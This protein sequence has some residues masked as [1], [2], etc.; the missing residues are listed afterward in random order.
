VRCRRENRAPLMLGFLI[1]GAIAVALALPQLMT[2]TFPQ[3]LGGG[4]LKIRFNWV[5]NQGDGTLIDGYFWFW[6]K[7]V[8]LVYLLIVPAILS[9]KKGGLCRTLG[10]GA[11]LIY[12][13]AELIQFQ[14]N[15]YDNNKLFYAAFMVVLPSVGLYLTNLWETLRGVRGRALLAAVFLFVCTISGTLT[16]GREIVSDYQLFSAAEAEAAEFI[17]E[18]TPERAMF[19]TGQ[20]HNNA[21]SALTGR[22]ILCGTGSYLYFHGIDYGAQ[23]AAARMLL[24]NPGENA[25]LF[26]QYNVDYAYISSQ[27]RYNFRVDEEWFSNNTELVFDNLAVQIYA[28]SEEAAALHQ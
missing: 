4:S 26:E 10:A 3:T 11:L 22:Y 25:A 9:G 6:I 28:V 2:W 12:I 21:V 17:K 13:V 24:E 15:E 1:Y 20:Q 8:G 23:Q 16:I 27:E 14:P 18:N 7:N 5:N 19:L